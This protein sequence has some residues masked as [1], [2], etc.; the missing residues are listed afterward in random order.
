MHLLA[1]MKHLSRKQIRDHLYASK[2]EWYTWRR[3]NSLR[4][5]GY[6]HARPLGPERGAASECYWV[7]TRR[8]AR[9]LGIQFTGTYRRRPTRYAI[10]HRGLL[11]EITRQVAEAGW[12]LITPAPTQLGS[13]SLQREQVVKA[14]LKREGMAIENLLLQ[15]YPA[16]RLTERIERWNAGH[17]GAVVPRKVNEYVAYV[18][19]HPEQTA[20]LIPHPLIAGRGFWTRSPGMRPRSRGR[21]PKIG[22]RLNRY[23][24][25]AQ[26]L[27]VLAV[28]TSEEIGRQ[29]ADL[30]AS[31]GIG[32][33]LANE[34]GERLLANG[35]CAEIQVHLQSKQQL[36]RA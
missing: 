17:V 24:R 6:V 31:H 36:V 25:L 8:G 20:L 23:S 26:I 33:T 12:E 1:K 16:N 9:E 4:K 14:V 13:E 18:P 10:E 19:G 29:Y 22:S 11:L 15:G 30:L 32:W 35:Q 27:P 7:L 3:L 28:F 21:Y 2:S 34:I 5:R